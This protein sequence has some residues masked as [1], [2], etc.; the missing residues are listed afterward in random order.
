MQSTDIA[1]VPLDADR[2]TLAAYLDAQ[3]RWTLLARGA[4]G[5][6]YGWDGKD[7]LAYRVQIPPA[8]ADPRYADEDRDM[9]AQAA[10]EI[11]ALTL[12]LPTGTPR[13]AVRRLVEIAKLSGDHRPGTVRPAFTPTHV[14]AVATGQAVTR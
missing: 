9:C 4:A 1:F 10:V 13:E 7:S 12:G 14:H 6:F 3:P 2:L 11:N 8:D 5:W